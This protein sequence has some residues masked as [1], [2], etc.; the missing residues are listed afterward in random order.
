M[1]VIDVKIEDLVGGIG[2]D[3]T[4]GDLFGMTDDRMK[5]MQ[6]RRDIDQARRAPV[7]AAIARVLDTD[8]GKVLFEAL[9]DLTFRGHVDVVGLGLPSDMALQNLLAENARKELVVQL[10]KLAREGRG[11]AGA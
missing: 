2:R 3:K 1:S 10:L 5:A 11:G 4:L 9:M 6:A 8:D 7:C